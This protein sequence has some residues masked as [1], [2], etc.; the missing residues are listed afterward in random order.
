MKMYIFSDGTKLEDI[1]PR[2]KRIS[3]DQKRGLIKMKFNID[4]HLVRQRHWL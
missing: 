2:V 1:K 4:T 3:T